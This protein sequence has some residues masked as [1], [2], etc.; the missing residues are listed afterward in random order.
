MKAHILIVDDDIYILDILARAV[1]RMGH[2]VTTA[3]NGAV[4][5]E[6]LAATPSIDI[7]FTDVL[8]P[9][10]SGIELLE[11]VHNIKPT[12]PVGIISGHVDRSIAIEALNKGAYALLEK[13]FDFSQVA[14][15]LARGLRKAEE[16]R[17]W[18]EL[19][20]LK[21]RIQEQDERMDALMAA[22]NEV[23]NDLITGLR[24]ELGNVT[25][26]IVLNLDMMG[27]QNNIPSEMRENIADLQTGADELI[28]LLSRFE[29]YPHGSVAPG[30]I[31][32]RTVLLS[33]LKTIQTRCADRHIRI[34]Y[35]IPEDDI[36]VSGD[37]NGLGKAFGHILQNATEAVNPDEGHVRLIAQPN[38]Q[39]VIVS[40]L[41]NGPGF[42][43]DVLNQPFSPSYT[44]KIEEGFVRGLGLGL[45]I[46]RSAILLNG[47][48][49]WLE[50]RE[51]GGA[52]VHV[53][54]PLARTD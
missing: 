7:I 24:H 51:E 39:K 18:D 4:G 2:E 17:A 16:A 13:P 8:M 3:A 53:Q 48:K 11:A 1:R 40:V 5:L 43:G 21:K 27:R 20:R 50:N 28:S 45:F 38:G 15:V 42:S 47:G 41:D 35:D 49:I 10:M 25:T 23:L 37:A 52:S 26:A 32:L 19:N 14:D 6:K 54:L 46:T 9:R 29:E 36:L 12:M 31:S 30:P 33:A 22:Q 34:D 44:T